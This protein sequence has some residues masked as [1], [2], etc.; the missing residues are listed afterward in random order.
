MT[1][2]QIYSRKPEGILFYELEPAV[3]ID[4]IRDETHPIFKKGK[5]SPHVS[6]NEWP[7]GYNDVEHLDYSWTGRIKARQINSQESVPVSE[8][9][10]IIPLEAGL[11][12]YPLVNELVIVVEYMGSKYYTRRLNTRNFINNSADFRYE[13]KYGKNDGV[14]ASSSANLVGAR[15]KSNI[16]PASGVYG[17]FLGKYFK[18]NNK[19][20]PLKHYEGDTILESRFGSSVRFG[21]YVDDPTFDVG[22]GKGHGESYEGNYGNPMILIRNR[23]HI[24]TE[25]ETKY[26]YN[27]LE[28][29]NRDGSSIH[30]TSGNTKSEFLS[31]I[32]H[33]YDNIWYGCLGC[34]LGGFGGL[35]GLSR[36]II[37][38]KK[39]QSID[40]SDKKLG[41]L[42]GVATPNEED[43]KLSDK[44]GAIGDLAGPLNPYSDITSSLKNNDL[45][46]ALG[47]AMGTAVGGPIGA[48]IGKRLGSVGAGSIKKFISS[49]GTPNSSRPSERK[50]FTK[51]IASGNFSLNPEYERGIVNS[52]TSARKSGKDSLFGSSVGGAISAAT[53]LGIDVPGVS[54]LGISS[55]DSPM[56]KIFKLA[57][58]G[59]KALCASLRKKHGGGY[60][61]NTEEKLGW[62]L[63][64]GI[65]LSLLAMLKAL[66]DR[67]RGL[68]FNFGSFGS[69]NL[70]NLL[71]DLCDWINQVEHKSTLVD[72]FRNES[73]KFLSDS[74]LT[75]QLGDGFIKDGT[76]DAYARNHPDFD[77]NYRSLAGDVDAIKEASKSFGQTTLALQKG[78]S[79]K[80]HLKFDPLTGLFREKQ[81]TGQREQLSTSGL[82]SSFPDFSAMFS[83]KQETPTTSQPPSAQTTSTSISTQITGQGLTGMEALLGGSQSEKEPYRTEPRPLANATEAKISPSTGNMSVSGVDLP[84]SQQ[85]VPPKSGT[86]SSNPVVTPVSSTATKVTSYMSGKE[87]TRESLKG[88]HLE[89]ADLNAVAL[90][91]ET[92]LNTLKDTPL[93]NSAIA[94][95]QKKHDETFDKEME[96]VEKSVLTKTDGNAIYGKQLPTLVGNQ[97]IINSERVLISSKTQETGIFSKKKFFVTTDD[98]ITLDAKERIV[99][100]TDSHLSIISPS[101]HLGLFTTQCHPTLKGDCTTAWLSDLCGWLSSHVHHDPYITTSRP[102]QQGSLASLR[103]RLPTLL[104]E[105]IFISG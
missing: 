3:V 9:D 78:G 31:T 51:A 86:R 53:S 17:S 4:V 98:E 104:S 103:A 95:A 99:M 2:R 11:I 28:D 87:I 67:L 81:P 26:Q 38:S 47:A 52:V 15:N 6:N 57:S 71:L 13:H 97:I 5:T 36:S 61:S 8:L 1:Q 76:Y 91:D 85:V 41:S 20:R 35:Y 45:G 49:P 43:V 56:F 44:L 63:S 83:G 89:S 12:E 102:A 88:T 77:M 46:G 105:R 66:F 60:G 14:T 93:M 33:S 19:V 55:N 48:K 73:N 80:A 16:S 7:A 94:D 25:D 50:K 65:D 74:V 54:D 82:S 96:K 37:G 64:I 10:W 30:I 22:T 32:D 58:F 59:L 84:A 18:S 39:I 62:L 69:F 24:T 72:T 92:D 21:C 27:I 23:Q 101:V 68:K 100:R 40:D 79:E 42:G 34:R 75:Q 70:N 90:L 29:I